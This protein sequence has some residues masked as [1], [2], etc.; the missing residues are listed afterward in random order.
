MN[1]PVGW[2]PVR[3]GMLLIGIGMLV[4]A[5]GQLMNELASTAE[6]AKLSKPDADF[7]KIFERIDLYNKIFP[8]FT[9]GGLVLVLIGTVGLVRT[10]QPSP[11]GVLAVVGLC[12]CSLVLL[13][14]TVVWLLHTADD[15]SKF[16]QKLYGIKAIWVIDAMLI[17]AMVIVLVLAAHLAMRRAGQG[18]ALAL[19]I[20]TC[21]LAGLVA[22]WLAYILVDQPKW[23]FRMEHPW[24]WMTFTHLPRIARDVLLGVTALVGAAQIRRARV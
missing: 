16:L 23:R 7:G 5:G 11:A 24:Q 6:L 19:A 1:A 3:T 12:V 8:L 10:P 18:G 2:G 14:E 21:V 22:L 4:V 17:A 9:C 13:V 15:D 20:I